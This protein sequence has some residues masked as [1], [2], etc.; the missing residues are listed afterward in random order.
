M[1]ISTNRDVVSFD[2]DD[3]ENYFNIRSA[4]MERLFTDDWTLDPQTFNFELMYTP[5]QFVTGQLAESYEFSDP[6]TLVIHL[7]QGIHWQDVPPAN[8]REFTADDVV[9][10]YDRQFG[11]GGSFTKPSPY[12]GTVAAFMYLKSVTSQDKYTVIFKWS[13]PNPEFILETLQAKATCGQ[14]FE[15]PEA[16]Q[17]WGNL[18]DWHHAIGTGPFILTD[19]VDGSSASLVKNP[20]YWGY[21]EHYPQ[22]KLPYIDK[23]TFLII[24]DQPTAIAGLRTGKI[25]VID[26]LPLSTTQSVQKTNPEILQVAYVTS[27]VCLRRPKK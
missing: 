19:F 6:S 12:W 7:R 11:L 22:N 2:P 8:G 10:H 5:N 18:S 23:L 3:S 26:G 15:N 20:N 9:F 17:E 13:V 14:V 4:W 25:D 21:D 27:A 1:V 16:V 24:P